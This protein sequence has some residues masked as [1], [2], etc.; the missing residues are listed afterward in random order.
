MLEGPKIGDTMRY[1]HEKISWI[2]LTVEPADIAGTG[3]GADSDATMPADEL[4]G[5]APS[6]APKQAA[7]TTMMVEDIW[8]ASF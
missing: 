2:P 1:K 7:S 3:D 4:L 6:A 5:E 8:G